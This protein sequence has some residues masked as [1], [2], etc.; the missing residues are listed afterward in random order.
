[1]YE[2]NSLFA[3]LKA[4]I[5]SVRIL[6][7]AGNTLFTLV[8]GPFTRLSPLGHAPPSIRW[9]AVDAHAPEGTR[10]TADEAFICRTGVS[11]LGTEVSKYL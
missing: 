9:T 11:A 2:V 4:E 8:N 3:Q 10:V 1:M 5:L 7:F 6:S